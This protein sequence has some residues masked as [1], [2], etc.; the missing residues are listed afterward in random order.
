MHPKMTP[1]PVNRMRTRL[2]PKQF[3]GSL[4]CQNDSTVPP[5]PFRLAE[6][7]S[8]PHRQAPGPV[9]E[10]HLRMHFRLDDVFEKACAHTIPPLFGVRKIPLCKI[11]RNLSMAIESNDI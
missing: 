8:A 2:L 6:G 3:H 1:A 10:A 7:A 11:V 9:S 5:Y 4:L